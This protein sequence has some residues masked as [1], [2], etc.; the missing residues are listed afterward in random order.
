[1]T[2]T[3]L[4]TWKHDR[5]NGRKISFCRAGGKNGVPNKALFPVATFTTGRE[6]G[7]PEFLAMKLRNNKDP[8]IVD[9]DGFPM[10][11]R[12]RVSRIRRRFCSIRKERTGK[13]Y[14]PKTGSGGELRVDIEWMSVWPG[15]DGRFWA[16]AGAVHQFNC[17]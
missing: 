13:N 14:E 6:D 4:H 1:M 5:K 9:P 15:G 7:A 10:A 2:I 17:A 8:R 16:D 11:N 3:K 12:S